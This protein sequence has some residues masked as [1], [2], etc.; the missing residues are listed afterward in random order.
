M[1]EG[2]SERKSDG[3]G[4]RT[5]EEDEGMHCGGEV[6]GRGALGDSWDC[7]RRLDPRAYPRSK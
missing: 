2:V 4:G 6:D 1:G 7:Y 5:Q 3:G